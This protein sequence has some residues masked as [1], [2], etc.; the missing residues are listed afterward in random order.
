MSDDKSKIKDDHIVLLVTGTRDNDEPF[1]A[2][3]SLS[4]LRYY[5]FKAA[6][7]RG[8]YNL[9]DFGDIIEHGKGKNPPAD[10]AKKMKDQYGLDDDFEEKLFQST[11]SE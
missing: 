4:P 11:T 5:D 9:K 8:N 1:W 10:I 7:A 2:Y 3:L 6:E